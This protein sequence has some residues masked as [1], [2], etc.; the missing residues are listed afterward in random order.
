M[1]NAILN[2]IIMYGVY[3]NIIIENNV[4]KVLFGLFFLQ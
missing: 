1:T 2:Y 3:Q 4:E